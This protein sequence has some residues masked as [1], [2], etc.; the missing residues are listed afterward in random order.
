MGT[1][2]TLT[3]HHLSYPRGHQCASTFKSLHRRVNRFY[4]YRINSFLWRQWLTNE[5]LSVR[6]PREQILDILHIN[7]IDKLR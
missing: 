6:G 2:S 4:S 3:D 5:T 1:G 7:N